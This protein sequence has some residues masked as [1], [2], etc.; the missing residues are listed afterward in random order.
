MLFHSNF[1]GFPE[2]S[3]N[4][5]VINPRYTIHAQ[6]EAMKDIYNVI[7]L[8]YEI[9]TDEIKIFEAKISN[10]GNIEK[11]AFRV[12][13]TPD[14]YFDLCM[15]MLLDGKNTIKTVWLNA[16]NDKH[17]TLDADKYDNGR[18]K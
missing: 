4:D 8:P 12:N 13:Y 10:T 1:P 11:I 17:N 3:L 5:K 6:N 18:V 14:D 16:K 15:V 9:A 7:E 2:I